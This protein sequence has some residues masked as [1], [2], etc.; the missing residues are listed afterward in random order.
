MNENLT[1]RQ[2]IAEELLGCSLENGEFAPCPGDDLHSNRGGRRDFL[3]LTRKFPILRKRE[4]LALFWVI[5]ERKPSF[6]TGNQFREAL[7]VI[8]E[9]NI[10]HKRGLN[11]AIMNILLKIIPLPEELERSVSDWRPRAEEIFDRS[12]KLWQSMNGGSHE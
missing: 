4:I 10:D 7:N 6:T 12:L 5:A 8:C 1:L 9:T 11:A 3:A 2:A